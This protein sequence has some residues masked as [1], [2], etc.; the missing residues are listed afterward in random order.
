MIRGF[1]A[2]GSGLIGQQKALDNA[3]NNLANMN[4][5]GYKKQRVSFS[6]LLYN[7]VKEAQ[8]G[9]GVRTAG[10]ETT[11]T[12]GGY[13]ET[14]N[15]LDFAV[16]SDGFFGVLTRDG[17]VKYTRDGSFHLS[18]EADGS[19]LTTA[20]GDYVLDRN[21]RKIILDGED[22]TDRIGVFSFANSGGLTREG[23]NMFSPS[24]NSGG[25]RV[26]DGTVVNGYL[27]SSNVELAGEMSDL[28]SIQ[29]SFQFNA[30][31]L[32]TADEIENIINS[33]R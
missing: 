16:V 21:S 11:H 18:S 6:E 25:R 23:N 17:S 3:A 7:N 2:A 22:I 15:P 32:Q 5:T 14:G 4:T 33:L 8:T 19:Y 9:N 26:T 27:E 28:I 13:R 10:V 1:Y 31:M 30:K 20:D 24:E 12:P 29:K